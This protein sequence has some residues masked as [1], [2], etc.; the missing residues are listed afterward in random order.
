M[1]SADGYQSET[2]LSEEL[3]IAPLAFPDCAIAIKDMLRSGE[4]V[5]HE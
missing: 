3:T 5:S 4:K 1:P 2:I